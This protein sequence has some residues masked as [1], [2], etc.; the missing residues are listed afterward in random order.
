MR[1]EGTMG[2]NKLEDLIGKKKI[3]STTLFKVD[4]NFNDP[5]F[6]RV[7]IA[8]CHTGLNLNN[9]NIKKDVME[10]AAPTLKNIPI[11][12]SVIERE[13]GTYDFNGHDMEL[14]EDEEAEEGYSIHYIE[15]PVGT[16]PE[17]NEYELV[18]DET[19]GK[20]YVY[21]TGY[22]YRDYGNKTAKIIDRRGGKVDVSCEIWCD[23]VSYNAKEKYLDIED[24]MFTGV[25][26]LGEHVKPGMSGANAKTF[27]ISEDDR[28]NQ[29]IVIMKE[30]TEALNNYNE[31]NTGKGGNEKLT[32]LEELLGLYNKTIE[33]ITFAYEELSDEELELKFAEMFEDKTDDENKD[34]EQFAEANEGENQENANANEQEANK[35]AEEEVFTAEKLFA[36]DTLGNMTLI[37]KVSHEDIRSALYALIQQY[38]ELDEE[39]Y[40]ID[41]VY[42]N[43]FEFT[44]WNGKKIFRQGYKKEEDNISF[45]GERIELFQERLTAT[46]KASLDEM[47]ANYSALKEFKANAE[48]KQ[49]QA[50]KD[51]IFDSEQYAELVDNE[52]FTKLRNESASYSLEDIEKECKIIFAEH[53]LAKGQFSLQSKQEETEK[54]KKIMFAFEAEPEAKPY[55]TLFD[56]I[57]A[58]K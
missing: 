8:V 18:L 48:E 7:K 19:T 11:L 3:N 36:V 44:N 38:E 29:M 55:G 42:D 43:E 12:A 51:A 20:H 56:K 35:E 13:D 2:K 1:K 23:K 41:S 53:V 28:D 49:V 47:R 50:D 57:E 6:M 54:S 15:V 30:L 25:T 26:L 27:S 46:E 14:V 17:T 21:A 40:Y 33:E 22:I 4:E 32:K 37:Y 31:I 9:S 10:L 34:G 58:T 39:W 45:V 24:F 52:A 16:I 5:R